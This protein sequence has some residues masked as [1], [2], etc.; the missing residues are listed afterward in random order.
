MPD[1]DELK[2]LPHPGPAPNRRG[3]SSVRSSRPSSI[4]CPFGENMPSRTTKVHL[5]FKT[6]LDI[7]FT[8]FAANVVANYFSHYI[9]KAIEVARTLR[10]EGCAERFVWTTGSWLIYE[11]L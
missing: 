5:I 6:H 10:E 7:G 11:Y 8:D 2:N 9:P 1:F 4:R 3:E